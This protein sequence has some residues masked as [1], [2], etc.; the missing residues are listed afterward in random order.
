MERQQELKVLL[1]RWEAE[2]LRERQRKPSQADIEEA[3][4]ETR[5]LYREY[6]ELKRLQKPPGKAENPG[7]QKSPKEEQEEDLGCWGS[8]LNRA[9]QTPRARQPRAGNSQFCGIR[10]KHKLGPTGKK[11]I[12]KIP[13]NSQKKNPKFSPN[14]PEFLAQNPQFFPISGKFQRLQRSVAKTFCS[15]DPAWIQRVEESQKIW[16]SQKN[17]KEKSQ[18]GSGG[19]LKEEEEEE[20]KPK[21]TRRARAPPRGNFVRLNLKRK[22]YSR[23][24]MRGKFLRKQVWKQKWRKKFGGGADVCFRCGGKGHWASECRGKD[25]GSFP[26]E[27][28]QEKPLL[29]LDEAAQRTN[30]D[31]TPEIPDGSSTENSQLPLDSLDFPKPEFSPPSPP[32]PPLDPLY[33][34]N[35]DG[36][37]PDP[38]EEVLEALRTLGFDSF[39]PGQAEAVM[40]VL[41]GISTLLTLPTGSGK[42]LCYQLPFFPPFSP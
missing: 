35:P 8:H 31:F 25:L 7:A 5:R 6:R 39:R 41:C 37:I 28:P 14:S 32:P 38:P 11:I 36:T 16:E 22:S 42:S 27:I 20:E 9:P 12:L 33:P 2:F 15:L 21:A 19:F 13:K 4:E 18:N 1:K 24:S 23:A 3:P 17:E 30:G 40:R 10:L 34:P 26:E 29:T